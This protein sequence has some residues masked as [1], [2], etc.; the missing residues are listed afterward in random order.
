[1]SF[2]KV[3]MAFGFFITHRIFAKHPMSVE[4]LDMPNL[5]VLAYLGK[6]P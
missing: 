2:Q 5:R 1:M 3:V 4:H 6:F